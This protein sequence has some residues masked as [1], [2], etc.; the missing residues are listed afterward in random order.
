MWFYCYGNFRLINSSLSHRVNL[1]LFVPSVSIHLPFE[2]PPDR[3]RRDRSRAFFGQ[4]TT[5]TIYE[6]SLRVKE[7]KRKEEKK[8]K[9]VL[10]NNTTDYGLRL[11]F[12][13]LQFLHENFAPTREILTRNFWDSGRTPRVIARVYT[14]Y[15]FFLFSLLFFFF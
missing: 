15:L 5:T 12:E 6:D 10:V 8:D 7:K 3:E 9:T 14:I 1:F 4:T 13:R 11:I 2:R